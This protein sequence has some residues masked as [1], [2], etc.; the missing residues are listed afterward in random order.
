MRPYALRTVCGG[1]DDKVIAWIK[2]MSSK[3]LVVR[4]DGDDD[5][6]RPHWHT[7]FWSDKTIE[8]LRAQFTKAVP[9]L[10]G[11]KNYSMKPLDVER[12]PEHERYVCH[13]SGRGDTVKIILSVVELDGKYGQAWAQ[14]QN[15][16]FY[17][18]QD[19]Y[20][21]KQQKSKTPRQVADLACKN[22][23]IKDMRGIASQLV[24]A[25]DDASKPMNVF[26]MRSEV[27]L[28]FAKR[29]GEAGRRQIEDEI[30][31]GIN[32]S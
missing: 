13:A 28:I 11:N 8:N 3:Y 23:G 25:Y 5:E 4:H 18:R 15:E 10:K 7:I 30:L 20:K 27:R 26:H 31:S 6:K 21:K 9:M 32:I 19:T 29:N 16:E 14:A 1:E 2:K 12:L 24:I 17:A 22:L